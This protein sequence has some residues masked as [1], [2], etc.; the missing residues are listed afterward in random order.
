MVTQKTT[1]LQPRLLMVCP[2]CDW[3]VRIPVVS[4]QPARCPR[5]A[6]RL[7]G[8]PPVA[9]KEVLALSVTALILGL[10]SLWLPFVGYAA[11]GSE[12][13]MS[14]LDTG[15]ELLHFHERLLAILVLFTVAVIP[16]LYLLTV[17][18]VF[19][20]LLLD[21]R[22]GK[23]TLYLIRTLVQLRVWMMADV[24]LLGALVALIKISG[25]A[26][27]QLASG[28]YTYIGFVVVLLICADRV[29]RYQLWHLLPHRHAPAVKTGRT[30]RQQQLLDCV[31][32]H[33]PNHCDD[34]R[35]WRC[36]EALRLSRWRGWKLTL[37]LLLAAAF[38]LVPAH[39]LPVMEITN[40]GRTEPSTLIAGV[41]D[42]WRGGD[43]AIAIIVFIA[44]LVIPVAKILMLLALLW[45]SQRSA[46]MPVKNRLWLYKV[47]D[48]IG[49]W[50]MVDI[51]VV[52]VLVALVRSGQLMSVY[53]G[54]AALAFAASVILT[55][56]AAMAFDTRR[57]F[58]DES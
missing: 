15:R 23:V 43:Q 38:M 52:A 39:L 17:S 47:T 1:D 34:D 22:L 28:F 8:G 4:A 48:W 46:S 3:V 20:R 57:F 19:L 40:L 6:H 55:M 30:A 36:G 53:P 11:N 32:C 58:K 5:C 7:G 50:S 37:A 9:A 33:A 56:L 24:F 49:R 27:V 21:L 16:L 35:C 29:S 44:S 10:I 13:T 45:V 25:L 14:L 51:F 12:Q 41:L 26:S 31:C 18:W 2:D 54:N 42:L